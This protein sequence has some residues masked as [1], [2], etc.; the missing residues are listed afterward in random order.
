MAALFSLYGVFL[1]IRLTLY[2]ARHLVINV[3]EQLRYLLAIGIHGDIQHPGV[4]RNMLRTILV[5][6]MRNKSKVRHCYK[7]GGL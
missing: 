4:I 2:K 5:F 1:R 6:Q 7:I 3:F